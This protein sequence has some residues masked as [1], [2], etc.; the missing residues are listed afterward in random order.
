[1]SKNK[2]LW[3]DVNPVPNGSMPADVIHGMRISDAHMWSIALF[4]LLCVGGS[5]SVFM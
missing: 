4:P 2:G 3:S 1:M 5:S